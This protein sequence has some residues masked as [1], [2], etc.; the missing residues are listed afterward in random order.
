MCGNI[1]IVYVE[2][3]FYRK[4]FLYFIIS[5]KHWRNEMKRRRKKNQQIL[6][7]TFSLLAI[8]FFCLFP[9]LGLTRK[10]RG[11]GKSGMVQSYHVFTRCFLS[12]LFFLQIFC[13]DK[14]LMFRP[15][16]CLLNAFE[17]YVWIKNEIYFWNRKIWLCETRCGDGYFEWV[18]LLVYVCCCNKIIKL[19][20]CV[21]HSLRN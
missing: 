16:F 5:V 2:V 19:D 10:K 13:N 9:F 21:T 4:H 7:L 20:V 1:L 18:E 15:W 14:I 11:V 6:H 17:V 12:F 8:H 3:S